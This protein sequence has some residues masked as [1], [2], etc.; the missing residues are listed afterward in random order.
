M[1]LEVRRAYYAILISFIY[2]LT[3]TEVATMSKARNKVLAG[4][5]GV[6]GAG[7]ISW[8]TFFPWIGY[9]LQLMRVGKRAGELIQKDVTSGRWLI[10]MFEEA[11]TKHPKKPFVI[12][13]GK[14]YTYEFMEQQCNKV[15][16]I[17]L[18]WGLNVGETVAIMIQ[19]EPAFIW[20]FLGKLV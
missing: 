16:N 12:F 3:F 14:I 7:I 13:E 17:A 6:V 8:R 10:N 18:Q 4:V 15:A 20:T 5:A 19:N 9:D 2:A 1:S 11:V